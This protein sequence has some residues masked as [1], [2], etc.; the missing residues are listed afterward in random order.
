MKRRLQLGIVVS[1]LVLAGLWTY[2]FAQ[3]PPSG[4]SGPG[5]LVANAATGTT[6]GATATLPAA[7]GKLTYI[8]GFS[9]SAGSAATAITISIT[10]TALATFVY[11]VG[12]PVTAVGTTGNTVSQTFT[13]CLPAS[14]VNTTITVAAGALGAS[15]VGQT[16]NAY[17]YQR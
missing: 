6:A 7:A 13:P 10:L 11:T 16:V 2:A 17:G 9:A 14:A 1:A 5:L 4:T 8:C 12:A 15:G 3:I